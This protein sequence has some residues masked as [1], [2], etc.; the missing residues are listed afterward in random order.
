MVRHSAQKGRG[1]RG[2]FRPWARRAGCKFGTPTGGG[3][4][5]AFR[6]W[7]SSRRNRSLWSTPVEQSFRVEEVLVSPFMPT[8]RALESPRTPARRRA[9]VSSARSKARQTFDL[10]RGEGSTAVWRP[11]R[12][13][14]QVPKTSTQIR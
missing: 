3:C 7:V 11:P 6:S 2:A 5:D 13:M 1:C 8:G 14:A 10:V 12:T 4:L 9:R